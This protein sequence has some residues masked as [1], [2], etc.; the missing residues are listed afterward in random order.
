MKEIFVV[1]WYL[2]CSWAFRYGYLWLGGFSFY[3]SVRS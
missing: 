3:K 2:A 1:D